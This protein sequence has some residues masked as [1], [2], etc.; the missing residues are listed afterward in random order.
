[1]KRDRKGWV[2][3]EE[4]R[5]G[6]MGTLGIGQRGAKQ[7]GKRGGRGREAVVGWSIE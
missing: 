6:D 3:E 2:V 1:L 5:R 4:Y 7:G